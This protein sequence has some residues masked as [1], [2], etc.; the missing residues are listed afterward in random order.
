MEL[1]DNLVELPL[2]VLAIGEELGGDVL[3]LLLNQHIEI[4]LKC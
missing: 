3:Y 2:R 1:G 4:S